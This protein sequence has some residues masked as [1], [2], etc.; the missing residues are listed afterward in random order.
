MTLDEHRRYARQ[1]RL[2]SIGETG[3]Q[4]LLDASVLII[5]LGGLGSPAAMYLAACGV[6]ELVLCDFDRVEQSNLQRQIIHS[7]GDVGELKADSAK[8]SL[9]RLN[10]R[11][12]VEAIDWELDEH[13]L[14]DR[15]QVADLVL[16]CTDNFET[17]FLLN[18]VAVK[19]KTPLVSGAAIRQEGQ[20]MSTLAGGLPCYQCVYPENL[21]HQETCA[22]EGVLAPM[23]GIIGSLQALQAIQIL[24]GNDD[25]LRGTLL[26]FDG[27]GMTWQRIQVPPRPDCP[28][29][30][31]T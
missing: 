11:C 29:C 21:E 2:P 31:Q 15:V 28:V 18:R 7:E 20:I 16:D 9:A 10:P 26:L 6:G 1:I 4:R 14:R 22:L 25:M 3:Q 30:G 19:E 17:R 23:V 13:E 27:M 24:T 12:H 8:R 5:G